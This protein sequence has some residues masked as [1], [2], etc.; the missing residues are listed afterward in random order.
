MIIPP[1]GV[2]EPG[3]LGLADFAFGYHHF[4]SQAPL[5]ESARPGSLSVFIFSV[6]RVYC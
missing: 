2:N 4:G 5:P 6:N 3:I 1:M